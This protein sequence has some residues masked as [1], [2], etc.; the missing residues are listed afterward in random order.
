MDLERNELIYNLYFK[1]KLTV[2]EISKKINL[3]ISQISRILSKSSLYQ[4][5]KSNRKEENRKKHQEQAKEI[6]R[7]KRNKK[8]MEEKQLWINYIGRMQ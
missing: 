4:Q 1:D 6:M 5:E 7:K 2:S 3:S 8:Q